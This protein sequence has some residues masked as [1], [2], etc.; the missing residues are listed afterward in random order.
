MIS[1]NSV[2]LQRVVL[3]TIHESAA[4]FEQARNSGEVVNVSVTGG[5]KVFDRVR[6]S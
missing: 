5:H 4:S 2:S 6:L 1:A 3:N